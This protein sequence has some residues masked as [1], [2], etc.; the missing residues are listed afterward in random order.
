MRLCSLLFLFYKKIVCRWFFKKGYMG[1]NLHVVRQESPEELITSDETVNNSTCSA[2]RL[3][4]T[5]K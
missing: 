3:G 4:E 5:H 1:N 2:V